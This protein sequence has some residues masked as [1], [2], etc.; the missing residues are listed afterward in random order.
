MSV[1]RRTP[2]RIGIITLRSTMAI[3]CS[4]LLEILAAL[5]LGGRERAALLGGQ[6][7]RSRQRR[8]DEGQDEPS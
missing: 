8:D 2:S 7:R 1:A 3:D 4:S 5:L 6:P